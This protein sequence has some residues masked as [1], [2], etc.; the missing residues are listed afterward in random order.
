MRRAIRRFMCAYLK[1]MEQY[2]RALAGGGS[3][4]ND[5]ALALADFIGT[6]QSMERDPETSVVAG[7]E[8]DAYVQPDGMLVVRYADRPR[9]PPVGRAGSTP[10]TALEYVLSQTGPAEHARF[11]D[12]A[13]RAATR[14]A[15]PVAAA[16]GPGVV[17]VV[18][19]R[20]TPGIARM[21][22]AR[23][24]RRDDLDALYDDRFLIV[25]GLGR[26][27]ALSDDAVARASAH[28]KARTL[29]FYA[30]LLGRHARLVRSARAVAKMCVEGSDA[31]HGCVRV[32]SRVFLP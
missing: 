20:P 1:E 6:V 4:G 15:C 24:G 3:P 29:A 5:P 27:R 14:A 23:V 10:S 18:R 16:E 28:V 19:V 26:P 30:D 31:D 25:D 11:R 2:Q 8:H 32:P 21:L 22:A 12:A 9:G 17:G 13:V 7:A